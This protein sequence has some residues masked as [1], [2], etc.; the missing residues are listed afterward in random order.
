MKT[1]NLIKAM[2]AD[3]EA[4]GSVG[5][6][7]LASAVGLGLVGS[8]LL[9]AATLAP[10]EL[11]TALMQPR[12]AFKLLVT[13][14]LAAGAAAVVARLVRPDGRSGPASLVAL[15]A[16]LLL[17]VGVLVELAVVDAAAWRTRLIGDNAVACLLSIPL[18]SAPVLAAVI[19][20]LRKGAPTRPDLAGVF[21][22][23]LGGGLGAFLYASH[24]PDDSPLF[25]ATW[26][27]LAIA[28][29]VLGSRV[30]AMKLTRW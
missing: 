14:L 8:L 15:A 18:L 7:A 6:G 17:A 10:R 21:A 1:E 29:V 28:G 9:Y 2:V 13:L 19:L 5:P 27:P 3:R 16:P 23:L 26:Y 22:G 24:C 30:L 4:D 12:F 20:F 11:S 25:V